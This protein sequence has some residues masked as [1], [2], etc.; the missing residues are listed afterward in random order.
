MSL[1]HL[2]HT[3][4]NRVVCHVIQGGEDPKD[5]LSLQVI[6]RKSNL[7]LMALLW[8][9]ICNLGDPMSLRHP[10]VRG[11]HVIRGNSGYCFI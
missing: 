1:R 10:V 2:Y 4:I 11:D 5:A 9:I 3:Y 6:F 8:K 7:Y